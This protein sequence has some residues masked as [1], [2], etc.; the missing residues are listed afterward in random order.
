LIQPPTRD[1]NRF[2]PL[3]VLTTARSYS[4]VITT[5]VGSHPQLADL[6]ELKLFCYETIGELERS[7]PRYWQARGVRHRSPGLVR[8]VAEYEF[9]G[10][11]P[12]RLSA[13]W[14]WLH[15]RQHWRGEDVFDTLMEHVSPRVAVEKSPDNI[16]T[17]EGLAR[18][19]IAYPRA[20]YLHLTRHPI[21]NQRSVVAH[22]HRTVPDHPLDGEPVASLASWYEIHRR[23]L[24]F[25]EALPADRY[26][27]VRSEDVLNDS[28][29][30]MRSVAQ[31]LGI[32]ATDDAIR[33]MQHPETSPF[34]RRA[35]EASGVSG[36][37][38]PQFLA[39]PV[40]HRVGAAPTLEP[41]PGWDAPDSTWET[42]AT[43]ASRFG[44]G[45]SVER[46]EA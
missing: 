39:D 3:F 44:Y 29:T 33:A 28:V 27:R 40:P 17:D 1:P 16:L 13:A 25:A 37:N 34:A 6:P 12:D 8:A 4:S 14:E 2:A 5:M 45:S 43:L 38:D 30:H 31:W 23:I 46:D 11:D 7:L 21:S 19:A 35:P 41:P 10:Q 15:E 22:R 18:M 32:R 9:G 36:G 26:S 20:R 24:H 42:I